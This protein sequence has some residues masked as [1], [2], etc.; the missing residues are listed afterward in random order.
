MVRL[1]SNPNGH[2]KKP[3]EI[4]DPHRNKYETNQEEV[5]WLNVDIKL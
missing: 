5:C 2:E 4:S 3:A 1:K